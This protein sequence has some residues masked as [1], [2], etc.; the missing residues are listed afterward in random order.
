VASPAGGADARF[1]VK[2]ALAEGT[3][4]SAPPGSRWALVS[5]SPSIAV[6]TT[7][8]LGYS[9][10]RYL[11]AYEGARDR[12]LE[13]EIE[14]AGRLV[15]SV[16]LPG[17]SKGNSIH[18]QFYRK[19]DQVHIYG[20]IE[21]DTWARPVSHVVSWLGGSEVRHGLGGHLVRAKFRAWRDDR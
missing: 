19:G 4:H 9:F 2:Q 10:Y 21:P 18:V 11:L 12:S 14:G 8:R 6:R 17:S 15:Y 7:G 16:S 1:G 13:S 20:H 5:E 3:D